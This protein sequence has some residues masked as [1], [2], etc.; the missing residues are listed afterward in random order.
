MAPPDEQSTLMANMLA[1]LGGL[2]LEKKNPP[3]QLI[4]A[5]Q[6]ISSIRAN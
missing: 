4:R 5:V 3:N 6:G 1:N 2:L